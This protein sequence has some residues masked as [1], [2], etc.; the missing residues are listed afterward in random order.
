M[1]LS[2]FW[3]TL[4][5]EL[6]ID[7]FYW[8]PGFTLRSTSFTE[9]SIPCK[10]E[11]KYKEFKNKGMTVSCGPWSMPY[12]CPCPALELSIS[13]LQQWFHLSS[14]PFQDLPCPDLKRSLTLPS[15]HIY[16]KT[17]CMWYSV[18]DFRILP[19]ILNASVRLFWA[20][21]TDAVSGTHARKPVK[22][23]MSRR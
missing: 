8:F 9:N 5:L 16:H 20:L 11:S 6:H 10:N 2:L 19:P 1:A 22:K 3:V 15:P 13:S 12:P 18:A 23:S 7:Q 4:L 17:T 21:D 14:H